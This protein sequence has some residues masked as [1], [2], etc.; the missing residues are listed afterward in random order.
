MKVFAENE[1]LILR[2][3]LPDDVAALFELDSKQ[4]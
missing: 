2:E 3:I 4:K 1:R